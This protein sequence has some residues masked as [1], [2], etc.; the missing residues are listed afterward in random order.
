MANSLKYLV[1]DGDWEA[2]AFEQFVNMAN[3]FLRLDNTQDPTYL[4]VFAEY[5]IGDGDNGSWVGQSVIPPPPPSLQLPGSCQ[6]YQQLHR[7]IWKDLQWLDRV[8]G[9]L[10]PGQEDGGQA[11]GGLKHCT[12]T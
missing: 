5:I 9:L 8:T 7:S 10:W 6:G 2:R 12:P 11:A 3:A 1:A 4:A